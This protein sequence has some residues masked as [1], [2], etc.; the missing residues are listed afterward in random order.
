MSNGG[1]IPTDS[2]R[3]FLAGST[4]I[5]KRSGSLVQ[6]SPNEEKYA[7]YRQRPNTQ[8]RVG[9]IAK[10]PASQ[11]RIDGFVVFFFESRDQFGGGQDF[12]DAADAL[13]AAPDFLPSFRF[14]ALARCVGAEAHFRHVGLRKVVGIHSG[15]DDRR[16]QIIAVHAGEQ[17]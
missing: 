1:S 5:R 15:R 4:S 17:V 7:S 11:R 10:F 8:D 12:A 2:T 3:P 13:A 9:R 6:R 16:L 14:G